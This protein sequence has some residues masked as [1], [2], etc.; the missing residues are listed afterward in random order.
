MFPAS[1]VGNPEPRKNVLDQRSRR[2][3]TVRTGDANQRAIQKPI[4]E[5]DLAPNLHSGPARCRQLRKIR[6]NARTRHNQ[7]LLDESPIDVPTEF[8]RDTGFAQ[9]CHRFADLRFRPRF[10]RRHARAA[11]RAKQRRR[12]AR[13]RQ[14]NH[15]HAFV[16]QLHCSEPITSTSASSTQTAQKSAPKSKI[17]R[18]PSTRSIPP[19]QNDDAAAPCEKF[20]SRAA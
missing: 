7:I 13:S 20:V 16:L 17:A 19:I 6:R 9:L 10:G 15:Q 1:S 11:R 8:Q 4:R 5:L 12:D 2:R 3:F 14:P 18:L